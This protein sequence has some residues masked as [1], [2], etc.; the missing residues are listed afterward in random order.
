MWTPKSMAENRISAGS[1]QQH[2]P[3]NANMP[4]KHVR[5]N[6]TFS[7]RTFAFSGVGGFL[8]KPRR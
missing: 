8:W 5:G 2:Q 4:K 3:K 6:E 1:L 7:T